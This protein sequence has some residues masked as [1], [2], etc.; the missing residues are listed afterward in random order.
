MNVNQRIEKKT[1]AL[2]TE[3]EK[4]RKYQQNRNDKQLLQSKCA[5]IDATGHLITLTVHILDIYIKFVLSKLCTP[6]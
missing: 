4:H 2:H 5:R 1:H 6:K 3:K